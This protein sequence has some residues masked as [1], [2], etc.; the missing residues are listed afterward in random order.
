MRGKD[1]DERSR[2][3]PRGIIPACAGKSVPSAGGEVK[4]EDH[5]RVCGE[6][7]EDL[8]AEGLEQ[9][10]SPRVRGKV[11]GG[12]DDGADEGIIPACA[13]KRLNVFKFSVGL[14]D[15]PRVCGEKDAMRSDGVNGLGSS[16]RVRGK[17]G[18]GRGD[19]SCVGII[20]ACAG[21]SDL[22]SQLA[23]IAE[24]HPRVCGEKA[25]CDDD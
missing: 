12:L 25:E 5:P 1:F 6:K 3:V 2:A 13:G 21:K 9:G 18:A 19:G 20:P 11:V 15:H 24:D 22:A 17:G 4:E 16:P 10:S 14:Q 23:T 7:L 8:G